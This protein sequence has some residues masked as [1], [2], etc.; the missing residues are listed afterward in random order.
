VLDAQSAEEGNKRDAC[1]QD[2]TP[3]VRADEQPTP[4]KAINPDSG[5][6]A[7]QKY[8]SRLGRK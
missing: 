5:E 7:H 6:H 4:R 2:G 3:D 1:E 8:R